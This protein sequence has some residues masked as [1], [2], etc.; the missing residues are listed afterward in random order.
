MGAA[1]LVWAPVLL[2][3]SVMV[4][5]LAAAGGVAPWKIVAAGVVAAAALVAL[6]QIRNV[7]RGHRVAAVVLGTLTI[8]LAPTAWASGARDAAPI[9]AGLLVIALGVAIVRLPEAA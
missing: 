8:L 5:G 3:A 4:P 2:I 9:I 6:F 7:I 1:L